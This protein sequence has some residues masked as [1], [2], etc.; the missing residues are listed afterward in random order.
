MFASLDMHGSVRGSLF[1]QI[2]GEQV[3]GPEF[4]AY[5]DEPVGFVPYTY[6]EVPGPY[7]VDSSWDEGCYRL[8]LLNRHLLV[9]SNM[10][11]A[12]HDSVP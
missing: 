11:L 2:F 7:P 10:F 12:S 9:P 8:D 3:G 5:P 6:I 4:F 1:P